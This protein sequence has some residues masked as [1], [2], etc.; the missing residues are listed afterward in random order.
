MNL[1]PTRAALENHKGEK[2]VGVFILRRKPG[3][4]P[5]D[6]DC[7]SAGPQYD[8][9]LKM[10]EDTACK[11]CL[12]ILEN[13]ASQFSLPAYHSRLKKLTETAAK[14]LLPGGGYGTS[15]KQE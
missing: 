14:G 7:R 8:V 3:N 10:D 9:A 6:I 13:I 4:M 5:V 11:L 1:Y 2:Q 12:E 15:T